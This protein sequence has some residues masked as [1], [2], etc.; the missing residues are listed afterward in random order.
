MRAQ[1]P[2]KKRRNQQWSCHTTPSALSSPPQSTSSTHVRKVFFFSCARRAL[3]QDGQ[4]SGSKLV[5][6]DQVNLYVHTA[7]DTLT[8]ITSSGVQN[9]TC[10]IGGLFLGTSSLRLGRAV[11]P[12]DVP[13]CR[14]IFSN[15]LS[16]KYRTAVCSA[17]RGRR[18]TAF[19]LGGMRGI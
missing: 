7:D 1:V 19:G 12:L 9:M 18:N 10:H 6:D 8:S 2:G 5:R 13:L 11:A 15:T 4:I 14:H 16:K 17:R 3:P